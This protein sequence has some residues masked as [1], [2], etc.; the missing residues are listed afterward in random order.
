[1]WIL[2]VPHS[3]K[4]TKHILLLK[5]KTKIPDCR[6]SSMIIKITIDAS[7]YNASEN[8]ILSSE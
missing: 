6:D 1:M 5:I 7:N 4:Q 3:C 2:H 8:I